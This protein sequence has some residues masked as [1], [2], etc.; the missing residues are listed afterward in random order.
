ML[1]VKIDKEKLEVPFE[2]KFIVT[3]RV[4]TRR[5]KNFAVQDS[6][7]KRSQVINRGGNWSFNLSQRLKFDLEIVSTSFIYLH[8]W[9]ESQVNFRSKT[10]A[11]NSSDSCLNVE[12]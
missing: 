4:T 11:Y 7:S 12:Q 2:C 8:D 3:D 6:F 1:A 9:R 10:Y 5:L